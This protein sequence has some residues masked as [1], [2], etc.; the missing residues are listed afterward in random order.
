MIWA[1]I[2]LTWTIILLGS[3]IWQV[4]R[5][6]TTLEV[7][8]LGR[9]GFMGGRGGSSL[10]EQAGALGRMT[11]EWATNNQIRAPE[12]DIVAVGAGVGQSGAD[13]EGLVTMNGDAT[14]DSPTPVTASSAQ[15]RLGGQQHDHGHSHHNHNHR[16]GVVGHVCS[17]VLRYCTQGPMLQLL[18]LDR[19]TKGQAGRGLKMAADSGGNPFSMGVVAVS[20]MRPRFLRLKLIWRYCGRQNCEDFWT[21]GGA[22]GVDYRALY[23]IP[24][25]GQCLDLFR[26][27]VR[28]DTYVDESTGFQRRSTS[29]YRRL[30]MLIPGRNARGGDYELVSNNDSNV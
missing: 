4:C 19:F 28:S 27:G 2:Q 24:Q 17:G 9:Y 1:S 25:D 22:L 29:A 10:R 5:Q 18:G 15:A 21:R 26:E 14:G 20:F 7:S 3:Q 8:N 16:C 6:M 13:E 23:E 12:R 11:G 30:R